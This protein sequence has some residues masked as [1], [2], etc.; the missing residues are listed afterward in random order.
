MG[1]ASRWIL[2]FG[3]S[4]AKSAEAN[5]RRARLRART[6]RSPPRERPPRLDLRM[7]SSKLINQWTDGSGERSATGQYPGL[8]DPPWVE[9][10]CL[11]A[12]FI[13]F[14][15]G[16]IFHRRSELSWIRRAGPARLLDDDVFVVVVLSRSPRPFTAHSSSLLL[17]F[18]AVLNNLL[19]RFI[20][21]SVRDGFHDRPRE[22]PSPNGHC[23]RSSSPY[24]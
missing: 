4:R 7:G 24:D 20:V 8:S 12:G 5:A 18:F 6:S 23:R 21:P 19:P 10:V 11:R 9:F 3:R 15:L 16:G 22:N 2:N 17:L 1:R 13:N 14:S